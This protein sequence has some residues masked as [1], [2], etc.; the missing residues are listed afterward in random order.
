MVG[1][2]LD[3]EQVSFDDYVTITLVYLVKHLFD[4]LITSFHHL[5]MA[6]DDLKRYLVSYLIV[7]N[8]VNLR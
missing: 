3:D 1:G 5:P 7:R 2:I 8:V 4:N 6:I